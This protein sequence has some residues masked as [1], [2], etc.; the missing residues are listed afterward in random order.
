LGR[1]LEGRVRKKREKS[2]LSLGRSR[3]E[4]KEKEEKKKEEKKKEKRL[5]VRREG[6]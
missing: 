5:G 4:K 6:W 3:K 2:L 1:G